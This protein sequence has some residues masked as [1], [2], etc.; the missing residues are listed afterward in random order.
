VELSLRERGPKW[1]GFKRSTVFGSTSGV[2]EELS[3]ESGNRGGNKGIRNHCSGIPC[4][5]GLA[6]EMPAPGRTALSS[7]RPNRRSRRPS[8]VPQATRISRILALR[9]AVTCAIVMVAVMRIPSLP[10]NER[11]LS[12]PRLCRFHA[13][14]DVTNVASL[15]K[16]T[17]RGGSLVRARS[18]SLVS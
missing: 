3:L 13:S 11:F 8:S 15:R 14:V 2:D 6:A 4:M 1:F 7:D 17:T 12:C 9:L 16:P 10:V 5:A 18:Q